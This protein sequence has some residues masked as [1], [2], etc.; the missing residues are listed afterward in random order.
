MKLDESKIIDIECDHI[1][2]LEVKK[3]TYRDL[4]RNKEDSLQGLFG[5]LRRQTLH[6]Y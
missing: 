6:L 5:N 3:I 2:T 1:R 4:E